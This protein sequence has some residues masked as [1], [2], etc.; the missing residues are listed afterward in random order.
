MK[1]QQEIKIGDYVKH[2]FL[3][4]SD[5]YVANVNNDTVL[6]RYVESSIIYSVELF[7]HEVELISKKM[8]IDIK[9]LS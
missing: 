9:A 5:L 7:K 8:G 2:C 3:P 6:V 4:K 1:E